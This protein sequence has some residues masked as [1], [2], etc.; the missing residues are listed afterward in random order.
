[1]RMQLHPKLSHQVS[2]AKNMQ[3]IDAVQEIVMQEGGSGNSNGSDSNSRINANITKEQCPWL[4]DEYIAIARNQEQIRRDFK[5]REK[6]L[7]YLS[8]IITDLYVDYTKLKYGGGDM[9]AKLPELQKLI[10]T[11]DIQALTR[12]FLN[13]K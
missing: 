4:S 3:I 11:A 1:M 10:Y 13:G 8:G 6:S 12:F 7:T 9:R 2:L 5:A